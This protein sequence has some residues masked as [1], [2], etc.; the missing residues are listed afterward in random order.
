M[1]T[2]V[3]APDKFRG[4]L[5]ASDVARHLAIG[6]LR[7]APTLTVHSAPVAD[8]G[9]GTVEAALSSGFEPHTVT[10]RGPLDD[11]VQ[12]TFAVRGDTAVIELAQ[13][14]GLQLVTG[15]RRP[16]RAT[17]HGTGQLVTAALDAGCRTIV[18]G[19]GGS[20][21]TDGGAGMLAALGADIRAADGAVAESLADVSRVGLTGLD[22]RLPHSTI[23][24][25]GDVGN[26]LYGP[27]GAAAV[28][29]PQKGATSHEVARLDEALRHWA[30][31]IATE[32]GAE[33]AHDR[34]SGAAGGVGFAALAV[35][36][37]SF[38]PGI[39][40]LLELLGFERLLD[41]ADLVITGEGS[42]DTQT[43]Q[44][45]APLGVCSAA[46]RR[47]LPTVAVAGRTTL[48]ETELAEA[49][50]RATYTLQQLEPDLQRC[51]AQAGELLETLAERIVRE[52]LPGNK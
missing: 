26:P 33:H 6:L 21:S 3:L 44:G 35:L 22:P 1:T 30:A 2:V 50:F 34:G 5:S 32:V 46:T 7:A 13:A 24:L 17:S 36:G 31:L 23:T 20:A 52:Q 9:E 8:G 27:S 45:K 15:D 29:G 38:R 39:E 19:I 37:A 12:A 51:M 14:S 48:S 41:G 4:S 16:M 47:G 25:A 40:L 42:L 18:L 11:P 43:L 10:V 28:F 49:G